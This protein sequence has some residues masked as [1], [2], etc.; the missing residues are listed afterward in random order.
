MTNK[1]R[2]LRAIAGVLG[3]VALV[4]LGTSALAAAAKKGKADS[5]RLHLAVTHSAG[6]FD[7]TAGGGTDKVLGAVVVTYKLRPLATPKG[8]IKVTVPKARLWASNG[9]L[10][11]S[12]SADLTIIDA[13][14]DAKLTNGKCSV[15]QGTSGQRGHSEIGTFT[16]TGNAS[17]G[18][19][20]L[21]TNGTYK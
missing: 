18:Q 5:S 15:P 10:S 17:T 12:A 4:V 13:K 9:R 16:G 1:A 8:T 3:A 7:F 19:Y 6:G 21:V 14:G 20:T 11:G 2:L